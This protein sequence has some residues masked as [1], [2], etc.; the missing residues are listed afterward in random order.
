MSPLPVR[1]IRKNEV[2]LNSLAELLCIWALR[3]EA[4]LSLNTKDGVT[5]I[6]YT[7][8]LTGHPEDPLHHPPAPTASSPQRC[9]RRRRRRGPA[10]RERDRHQA[11]QAGAPPASQ[12]LAAACSPLNFRGPQGCREV[13]HPYHFAHQREE[14]GRGG[15][16]PV[17]RPH[18][19]RPSLV[20]RG[21][22]GLE[23][24]G[25]FE[26]RQRFGDY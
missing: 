22:L 10:R 26:D 14:G 19:C 17:P 8:S 24:R 11:A 4:S 20:E 13:Q 6:A 12:P 16:S 15:S 18:T 9:R 2:V 23:H 21:R 7:H 1:M 25:N 3:G 5:T